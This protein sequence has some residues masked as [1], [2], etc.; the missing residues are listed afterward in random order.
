M[1]VTVPAFLRGDTLTVTVWSDH[2]GLEVGTL[3]IPPSGTG[4]VELRST[5]VGRNTVHA[6]IAGVASGE[7]PVRY[8]LPWPFLIAAVLGG[9]LGTLIRRRTRQHARADFVAGIVAG[10]VSAVAYAIGLNLTGIDINVRV[11]GAAVLVVATLGAGLELPGL[12][13]LRKR[14]AYIGADRTTSPGQ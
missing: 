9:V 10:L 13:T 6:E 2:G 3:R 14:I 11:G 1:T 7:A 12:A 4:E 5:G 8:T